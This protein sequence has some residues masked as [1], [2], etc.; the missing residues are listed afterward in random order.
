MVSARRPGPKF[1]L[2]VNFI[3]MHCLPECGRSRRSLGA[4]PQ[5]RGAPLDAT[6]TEYAWRHLFHPPQKSLLN[7][8]DIASYGDEYCLF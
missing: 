7:P 3:A 5:L 1:L 4:H 2:K 6:A 8:P